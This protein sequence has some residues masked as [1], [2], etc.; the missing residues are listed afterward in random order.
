MTEKFDINGSEA[1]KFYAHVQEIH[2]PNLQ[3]QH[4]YLGQS[5]SLPTM[6]I[7]PLQRDQFMYFELMRSHNQLYTFHTL[8]NLLVTILFDNYAQH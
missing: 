7:F 6:C 8:V 2:Q 3:K 4:S 1:F 5:N